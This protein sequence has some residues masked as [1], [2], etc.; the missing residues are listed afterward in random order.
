MGDMREYFL[1]TKEQAKL[2]K[3]KNL[4]DADCSIWKKHTTYHWFNYLG[5]GDKV[6]YWPSTNRMSIRGKLF[7]AKSKRGQSVFNELRG[8]S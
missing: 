1:L 5:S 6:E 2:A 7:S 8:S 4:A 3:A